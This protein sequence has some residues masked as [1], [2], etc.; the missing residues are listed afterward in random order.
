MA[1]QCTLCHQQEEDR[2]SEDPVDKKC[3]ANYLLE[4]LLW[5]RTKNSLILNDT[6]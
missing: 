4:K 1:M 6:F 2:T 3:Q 5:V